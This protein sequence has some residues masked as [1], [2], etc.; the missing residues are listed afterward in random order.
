MLAPQEPHGPWNER[1]FARDVAAAPDPA[2]MSAKH[3]LSPPFKG[4][5]LVRGALRR[6]KKTADGNDQGDCPE[7]RG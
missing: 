3:T 4:K 1:S 5:D 6:Q 7:R 2:A